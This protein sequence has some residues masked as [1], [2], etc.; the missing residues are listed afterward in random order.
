MKVIVN[1]KSE[2]K[3]KKEK[4][5]PYLGISNNKRII[6]FTGHNVGITLDQGESSH[7][8]G[9]YFDIWEE[10]R[11]IPFTGEIVLSNS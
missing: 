11:F 4:K 8:V 6:L 1:K 3:E 7:T 5:Y 2:K 10:N 9:I